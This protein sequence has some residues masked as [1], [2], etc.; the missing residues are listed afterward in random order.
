MLF[1]ESNSDILVA[2]IFHVDHDN[3]ACPTLFENIVQSLNDCLLLEGDGTDRAIIGA[4]GKLST[5]VCILIF[6]LLYFLPA[7]RFLVLLL[8]DV[9]VFIYLLH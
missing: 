4:D 7:L 9:V 1:V 5:F 8:C 3:Y 2:I 6:L